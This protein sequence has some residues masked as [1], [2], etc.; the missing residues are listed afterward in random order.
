MISYDRTSHAL[1]LSKLQLESHHSWPSENLG[2]YL[3]VHVLFV[4]QF[5]TYSS[6]TGMWRRKRNSSPGDY[7]YPSLLTSLFHNALTSGPRLFPH[8]TV[9]CGL[10]EAGWCPLHWSFGGS[11]NPCLVRGLPIC[12]WES[13]NSSWGRQVTTLW[14]PVVSNHGRSTFSQKTYF[15]YYWVLSLASW[16]WCF[17]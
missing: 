10:L 16:R 13:T 7:F 1:N 12:C 11:W 5:C 2:H 8:V 4:F 6:L 14:T 17:R 15:Q 9:W 3:P